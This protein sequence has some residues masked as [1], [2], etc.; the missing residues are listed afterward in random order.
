MQSTFRPLELLSEYLSDQIWLGKI[1]TQNADNDSCKSCRGLQT[2]VD[3]KLTYLRG[4][5]FSN[6]S[7]DLHCCQKEWFIK[8]KD[9]YERRHFSPN[10]FQSIYCIVVLRRQS[11][12][13]S[14]KCGREKV[15]FF[16]ESK[17]RSQIL[18]Y[19]ES[20]STNEFTPYHN[21]A[22]QS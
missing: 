5:K 13:S 11:G 20:Q 19:L 8:I 18:M 7:S 1:P 14:L 9:A 10:L 4:S 12:V 16:R 6:S 22:V 17:T 21:I 15:G 3:Q 2:K